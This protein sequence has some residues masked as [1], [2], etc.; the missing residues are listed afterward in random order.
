MRQLIKK[1]DSIKT[2][3]M[4]IT[5][6]FNRRYFSGFT[7]SAG[8]LLISE[9]K[10]IL[11]TDSRYTAQANRQTKGFEIIQCAGKEL[12]ENLASQC[13]RM[14]IKSLGIEEDDINLIQFDQIKDSLCDEVKLVYASEICSEIRAIKQG[15]EIDAIQKAAKITDQVFEHICK[16]IKRGMSEK[17]IALEIEY[18]L[19]KHGQGISFDVICASGENSALPHASPTNRKIKDGDSIVLDFGTVV[20]GYCS[21]FTRTLFVGTIDNELKKV[22]NTVRSAQECALKNVRELVS[23]KEADSF[24]RSIIDNAGYGKFFGHGLGHG[25]GL[26]I[27]EAPRVSY[28]SDE[29]LLANMVIT[30]EPGIYIEELGGVRIEDLCVVTSDGINNLCG[31]TKEII[32]L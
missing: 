9:K 17:D 12:A 4:L 16:F 28:L 5:S 13:N 27:H 15:F 10:S 8:M 32:Q 24:A 20:D 11:F 29:L 22:Y 14:G 23:C 3:A 31:S 6:K 1:L 2:D 19:K 7:G 30:I 26:D 25:V 21:D 18:Q